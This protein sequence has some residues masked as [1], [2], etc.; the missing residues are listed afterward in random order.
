M[1]IYNP[2]L[3]FIPFTFQ[4]SKN[5]HPEFAI[6]H[7]EKSHK[8]TFAS[9]KIKPVK[10]YNEFTF[11]DKTIQVA[12]Y[13]PIQDKEDIIE[14]AYQ[15]SVIKSTFNPLRFYVYLFLNIVYSYTN[16]N[17]SD[18]QKADEFKLFDLLYN[19]GL[20]LQIIRAIEEAEQGFFIMNTK[21]YIET[22]INYDMST[23]GLVNRSIGA[24]NNITSVISEKLSN[25]D[26]ETLQHLL[27]NL[28]PVIDKL[29]PNANAP[30]E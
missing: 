7:S 17:F 14:I 15:K 9:L 6:S 11:N 18:E 29:T 22:K 25:I 20:L 27:D 16:L 24:V 13:L 2:S 5:A 28:G 12:T 10:S 19:S 21:D 30:L 26:Q 23:A 3:N 1:S 4:E 8:T